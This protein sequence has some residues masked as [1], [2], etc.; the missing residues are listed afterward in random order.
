M[1]FRFNR[2]IAQPHNAAIGAR[3]LVWESLSHGFYLGKAITPGTHIW[4]R[5]DWFWRS[6]ERVSKTHDTE[7]GC[8]EE[9]QQAG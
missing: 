6:A 5:A 2:S 4:V 7:E 1:K 9:G 8:A 3:V